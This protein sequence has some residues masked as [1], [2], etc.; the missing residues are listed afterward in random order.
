[1][2]YN[3]ILLRGVDNLIETPATQPVC[4]ESANRTNLGTC[5]MGK[6]LESTDNSDAVLHRNFSGS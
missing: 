2:G 5:F 6:R 4:D 3:A 1:M